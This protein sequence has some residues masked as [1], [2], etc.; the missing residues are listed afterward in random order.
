MQE[1]LGIDKQ[2]NKINPLV[3]VCVV[4]YNHRHF[5]EQCIDSILNQKTNFPFELIIGED[6]SKDGTR[7]ICINYGEKYPDKIRLFLRRE[8]DKIWIDGSKTGRFNFIENLKEARGKYTALCDGDDYWIDPF[9]LQKQIDFLET[10]LEF[11]IIYHKMLITHDNKNV[12]NKLSKNNAEITTI[13]DLAKGNYIYSSSCVYRNKLFKKFPLWFASSPAGDYVLHMLNA[14]YGKIKMFKGTMGAY[15]IH[16][17][18]IWGHKSIFER[19]E[20]WL[21]TLDFLI[22][23]FDGNVKEILIQQYAQ[24]SV[25]LLN[26]YKHNSIEN[27]EKELLT[28]LKK[29]NKR[30]YVDST[31][32]YKLTKFPQILAEKID[33]IAKH[34]PF[35]RILFR[36]KQFI[37]YLNSR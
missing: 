23:F 5:I 1:Y 20:N 8:E 9:K 10:N 36:T 14:K 29:Y 25:M 35:N 3:S 18:N 27:K 26:H 22:T 31:D 12:S 21:K 28:K 16:N 17:N 11:S 24:T 34:Y 6:D 37:I 2:V 4:T 19:K 32:S 13:E 7:E 15:R 33:K 30:V